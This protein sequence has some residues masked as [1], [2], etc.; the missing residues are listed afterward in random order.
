MNWLNNADF[1]ASQV[2]VLVSRSV[3]RRE[4]F[5]AWVYLHCAGPPL[6]SVLQTRSNLEHPWT[7]ISRP[8]LK[9]TDWVWYAYVFVPFPR[10][11]WPLPL[12]TG[13][14]EA[15][16]KLKAGAKSF[17]HLFLMGSVEHI[18]TVPVR[19]AS[20]IARCNDMT[21]SHLKNRQTNVFLLPK[22]KHKRGKGLRG[23]IYHSFTFPRWRSHRSYYRNL[24][25]QNI[26]MAMNRLL[27]KCIS[28]EDFSFAGRSALIQSLPVAFWS[29]S[30][31]T[32][33]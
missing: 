13:M 28:W 10:Q 2:T 22:S 33:T 30:S 5:L 11:L 16:S 4:L 14:V 9:L 24:T 20:I 8:S 21:V 29:F 27:N 7:C 32:E 23:H 1:R 31:K 15:A 25:F 17:A 26:P 19:A 3:W 12:L 6:P 18:D